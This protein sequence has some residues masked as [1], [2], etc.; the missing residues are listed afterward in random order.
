MIINLEILFFHFFYLQYFIFPSLPSH[1]LRR[2]HLS[3]RRHIPSIRAEKDEVS[4]TLRGYE[5][6]IGA[7]TNWKEVSSSIFLLCIQKI[8][9]KY[10]SEG[11]SGILIPLYPTIDYTR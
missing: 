2:N 5:T 1:C 9:K 10:A 8:K 4:H 7:G 3:G 6:Y 11:F